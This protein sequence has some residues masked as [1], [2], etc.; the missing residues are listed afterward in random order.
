MNCRGRDHHL[1]SMNTESRKFP[2]NRPAPSTQ[3]HVLMF[4]TL[5]LLKKQDSRKANATCMLPYRK[6]KTSCTPA[7]PVTLSVAI[8]R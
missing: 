8:T 3:I 1:S 7:Q 4:A 2:A 5:V 6:K